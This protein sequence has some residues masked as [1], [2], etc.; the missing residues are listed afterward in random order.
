MYDE[1]AQLRVDRVERREWSPAAQKGTLTN[2]S[3]PI[4]QI[5][6]T[7]GA[8]EHDLLTILNLNG[9]RIRSD[10]G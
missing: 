5:W 8:Q 9:P 3:M 7:P 4:H 2:G 10:S 1:M 6:E